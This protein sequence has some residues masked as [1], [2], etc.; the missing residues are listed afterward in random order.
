MLFDE[1]ASLEPGN[2]LNWFDMC[3]AGLAR[4]E[5]EAYRLL[6][7]EPELRQAAGVLD[8]LGVGASRQDI[9]EYFLACGQELE[10]AA[11]LALTAG[12]E[13]DPGVE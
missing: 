2:V 4:E 8:A 7:A 10:L 5:Q 3:A 9:R 1:P 13:A 12:A 11:V 6:G